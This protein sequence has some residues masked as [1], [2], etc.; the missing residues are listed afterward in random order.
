VAG[1]LGLILVSLVVTVSVRTAETPTRTGQL[2]AV[3]WRQGAVVYSDNF[4]DA[5]SG[6]TTTP[7]SGATFAYQNGTYVIIP[8]GNLHWFSEAPYAVP[9][10]R[11]S[12]AVT[13]RERV[14]A[15]GGA[16]FGVMCFQ[17]AGPAQVRFEFLVLV[18][19]QWFVEENTGVPSPSRVPT[20]LKQGVV[21]APLAKATTIEGAC[22][23]PSHSRMTHLDMFVN[24]THVAD[25]DTETP[26]AGRGWLAA[27]VA[28]SRKTAP[29]KVTAT[30]FEERDTSR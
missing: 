5:S 29:S 15:P 7:E 18:D 23:T 6:W 25:L 24:G 27:I 2:G 17:G 12:A 20:I 4:K 19:G 14:S 22:G 11:M 13:A 10:P 16:G 26:V 1:V 21:G 8:T 9:V 28:D 30:H 3:R